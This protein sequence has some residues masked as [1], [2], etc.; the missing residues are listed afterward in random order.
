[1]RFVYS[2]VNY[3]VDYRQNHIIQAFDDMPILNYA[4]HEMT[5]LETG[6]YVKQN[7]WGANRIPVARGQIK[8][9]IHHQTFRKLLSR[10]E[11]FIRKQISCFARSSPGISLNPGQIRKLINPPKI[12]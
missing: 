5:Y 9:L 12:I 3:F 4:N 7:T 10:S 1:M 2:K 8:Y 6:P 11:F